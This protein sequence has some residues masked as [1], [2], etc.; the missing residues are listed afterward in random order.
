MM[1]LSIAFFVQMV[2]FMIGWY[3][4]DQFLFKPLVKI[5]LKEE[6]EENVL[7]HAITEQ[8]TLYSAQQSNQT[9]Q[10]HKRKDLFKHNI[11]HLKQMTT[12]SF[13]SLMCPIINSLPKG[14]ESAAIAEISEHIVKKVLP[15]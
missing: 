12:H 13:E 15:L 5:A 11:P 10:L 6:A 8:R 3:I 9:L 14:E 1:A 2:H 4:I 7:I